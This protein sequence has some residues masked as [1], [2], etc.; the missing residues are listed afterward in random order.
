MDIR[1]KK[2]KEFAKKWEGRG[3]EK[4]DTEKFWFEFLE[5]I[6][7]V[8]K[9]YEYIDTQKP[10]YIGDKSYGYLDGYIKD[11]KIIIEQK[12]IG[13]NLYKKEKQSDGEMLTPFYQ[14]KRYND[15]LV[16]AEKANYIIVSNFD[17]FIIYDMTKPRFP[18]T[19]I[20]LKDLEKEYYKFEIL[21]RDI[22]F[23][24][25]QQENEISTEAGKLVGK[26][27]DAIYEK[28][29]DKN[30]KKAIEDLNVLLVRLV[31]CFFAEDAGIFAKNQFV[32][33]L[34]DK[35]PEELNGVLSK[36]FE[37]LATKERS[38][39]EVKA[40][41]DFP[42]VN[43]G[44]FENKIDVPYLDD[45]I[46]NIIVND[47]GKNF[48]WER[49]NP[50][51]FGATFESTLD[52]EQRRSGGMHYTS[53][54]NIHKVIY[55]LFMNDLEDEF[56]SIKKIKVKQQR[57]N[58]LE[59]FREKLGSLKFLDP[60][61][62]SG[63]FLTETFTLLRKLENKALNE[64]YDVDDKDSG[65]MMSSK[66]KNIDIKVNIH[67]FYGIEINDFAVAVAKT[68]LWIAEWQCLR[69]AETVFKNA[70]DGYLP[71]KTYN[72]IVKGNAL[73]LD[74]NS[75]VTTSK[76]NYI[77]GNPPFVG[78]RI[79]NENQKKDL[80]D[81]FY[82]YANIGNLDY[83]TCWYKKCLD[84]IKGTNARC[85]L[86]SSNSITQG[87]QVA[88]LWKQ[89]KKHYDFNIDFAY[90]TFRWN[91]DSTSKGKAAVHCVIV[92]FSSNTSKPVGAS[93][94]SA[95]QR[96]IFDDNNNYV[97]AKN[98]NGYLLD[99]DDI[100]VES[101]QHPIC[102]VPEIGMGNQPI[103]DG[104]YLFNE[105]EMKEFIK[106]EP[107][108]KIHF[109]KWI[110][111]DELINRYY[112]YCLYLND[113]NDDILNSM[114]KCKKRVENVRKFRQNSSRS[115]T[116]K[117]A[118][119]PK[120]FQTENIPIDTYIAIPETSS[121]KR[122]YIPIAFL[123]PD[124]LCSNAIRIMPN[125]TLYHF[126]VLTSN[127]HMAWMRAVCG[128]LKSDYRYS[129]DI[130]YNN[131][132]WPKATEEQ[133]KKIEATAKEILDA[134]DLYKDY[135]LAELYNPDRMKNE[136]KELQNAHDRNNMAV[137]EAYG[138]AKGSKEYHNEGAMVSH[139]FKLYNKM[140]LGLA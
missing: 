121:E 1:S 67:Q 88:I 115:S 52:L 9:P 71:L 73:T 110:G 117:L 11:T 80:N 63:N 134:R 12:S 62:G 3:Q 21:V 130:V 37:I 96:M 2:A 90:T 99:A 123:T 61:C 30:D 32:N 120:K 51:I 122:A 98:I 133:K 56:E 136:F 19:V 81:V 129:K 119:T 55:P 106:K 36:L 101:R 111:S 50:T 77:M 94:T 140:T 93:S 127:I 40:Y 100:Y 54:E 39:Y 64:I 87:E 38:K 70:L 59:E 95:K 31:F 49:I 13:I 124:I 18:D 41:D 43:G 16:T 10:A 74:W 29:D 132:P 84:F 92:G 57:I 58:K 82:G 103:D 4:T 112:R 105:N 128:R 104:N 118:N 68:A 113:V 35:K 107:S 116:L 126:G 97:I 20:Q 75:I 79:M 15:S 83:V 76:I 6:F 78:A 47:C 131:F 17:T 86:V 45:N 53:L 137:M 48:D 7:D 8:K 139:L 33:L 28:I 14:A 42:Y 26:L 46:K 65:Y 66:I 27:Y 69:E 102:D 72:N 108:S 125:A 89:L 5:E 91:N 22:D 138:I 60:A 25:Y 135:S 23:D 85:A 44:L 34:S 114:P 109:K 24:P